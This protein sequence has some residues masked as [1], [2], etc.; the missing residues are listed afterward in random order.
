MFSNY[1]LDI[2]V[3]SVKKLAT[4]V[5]IGENAQKTHV[6]KWAFSLHNVRKSG[7]FVSF[8]ILKREAKEGKKRTCSGGNKYSVS[9]KIL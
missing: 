5:K 9:T 6:L 3:I 4:S 2:V 8:C 1:S 7:F